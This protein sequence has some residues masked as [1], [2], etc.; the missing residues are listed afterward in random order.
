MRVALQPPLMPAG[1]LPHQLLSPCSA[2]QAFV[3]TLKAM[4]RTAAR[5]AFLVHRARAATTAS[6]CAPKVS[7]RDSQLMLP[8][9]LL[10]IH[11]LR[12]LRAHV[13]L[14]NRVSLLNARLLLLL[15][16][17]LQKLLCVDTCPAS[18][19]APAHPSCLV[20]RAAAAKT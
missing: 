20:T 5:A 19:S 13:C 7:R 3:A 9:L 11:G 18:A 16:P 14:L 15:R 8:L 12:R 4:W 1:F 17:Y 2:K 10:R 6:V